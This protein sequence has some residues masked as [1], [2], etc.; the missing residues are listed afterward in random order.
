MQLEMSSSDSISINEVWHHI[1]KNLENI[2]NMNFVM[3]QKTSLETR[4]GESLWNPDNI[5]SNNFTQS[6]YNV[7]NDGVQPKTP[8]LSTRHLIWVNYKVVSQLFQL[9]YLKFSYSNS[10]RH[11]QALNCVVSKNN[12]RFQRKSTYSFFAM[13]FLAFSI[14]HFFWELTIFWLNKIIPLSK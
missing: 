3:I 14:I 5:T 1:L 2:T 7:T 11:F 4:T 10:V 8:P 9:I 13:D 6:D 12:L